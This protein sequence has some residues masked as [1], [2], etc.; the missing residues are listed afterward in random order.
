MKAFVGLGIS[1][2]YVFL[3]WRS[4]QDGRY[5]LYHDYG[6]IIVFPVGVSGQ[7]YTCVC[8][9]HG[10]KGSDSCHLENLVVS[11]QD[12]EGNHTQRIGFDS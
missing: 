1:E 9:M 5:Q 4:T 12:F 3:L 6:G 7:A 10:I 2:L 11:L 8:T